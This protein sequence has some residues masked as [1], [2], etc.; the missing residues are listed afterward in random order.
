MAD[1]E[2]DNQDFNRD[3]SVRHADQSAREAARQKMQE[4]L[5][6]QKEGK[7]IQA[8]QAT[9]EASPDDASNSGATPPQKAPV[10][11][12][13]E[14]M[15]RVKHGDTGMLDQVKVYSPFRTYFDNP[16]NSISAENLTGPFDILAGHKNFMTLLTSGDIVIRSPRGEE[17]ITIDRGIMH[18]RSN[19]VT[20]FLDV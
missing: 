18:V 9:L 10:E 12:N 17:R 14:L 11:E 3:D 19:K 5:K 2:Q 6:A 16:A 4:A 13:T 15:D 7:D 1:Q 8:D 20:V